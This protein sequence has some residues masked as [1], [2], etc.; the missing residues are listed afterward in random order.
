LQ[1]AK[2]GAEGSTLLD[3]TD[4]ANAMFGILPTTLVLMFMQL[5]MYYFKANL[6]AGVTLQ[7]E[8]IFPVFL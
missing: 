4:F 5:Q 7:S 2:I 8:V 1:V 6:I 3:C